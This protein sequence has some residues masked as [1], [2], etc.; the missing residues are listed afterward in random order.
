ML[1]R[2]TYLVAMTLAVGSCGSE[3]GRTA[4]RD[5]E[6]YATVIRALVTEGPLDP[7]GE[8]EEVD[9]IVYAGPIDEQV[10]ISLEVQVAV[11]EELESFATVRFVDDR[12]EAIDDDEEGEPVLERGVLLLLGT[13][14]AGPSPSVDAARYV[15]LDHAARFRVTVERSGRTWEV[16][17]ADEIPTR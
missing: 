12:D 14:P 6:V 10:D 9:R 16:V 1:R 7:G 2:L 17:N 13:V 3:D 15:D 5:A 4:E 8:T 11:V